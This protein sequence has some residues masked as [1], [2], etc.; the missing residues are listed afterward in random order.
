MSLPQHFAWQDNAFVA[1]ATPDSPEI[2]VADS[3]RVR[4]GTTWGLQDHV[5]RFIDGIKKQAL[6]VTL[7]QDVG[8][9]KFGEALQRKLS[10]ISYALP[11]VDLFPRISVEPYEN[12]WRIVLLVRPAPQPRQTTS[13]WIPDYPD[14]RSRPTVKGPDIHLMR[15]LVDEAPADDV[16]LHDGINV[17]ETTTGAL[18]LWLTPEHLV[19]CDATQQLA[20]ISAQRIANHARSHDILV[21]TRSVSIQELASGECSVWFSNTL[22]GISPITTVDSA[23]GGMHVV[24]H[25]AAAQWQAAWWA[26]FAV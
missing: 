12:S 5:Y 14:P 4:N 3:W 13:L 9:E 25:Q 22:H 7:L 15:G 19:L 16:V 1:I 24:A 2:L 11:G 17:H 18:L 23:A 21:T 6:S 10:D 20:S 26:M 8:A